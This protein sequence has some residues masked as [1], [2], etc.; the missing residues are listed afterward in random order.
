MV[1]NRCE[2]FAYRFLARHEFSGK[3][4]EDLQ[5]RYKA[6]ELVAGLIVGVH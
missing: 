3:C 1:Y 5:S 4:P 2:V 6:S